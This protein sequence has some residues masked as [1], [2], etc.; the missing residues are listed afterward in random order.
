MPR[1]LAALLCLTFTILTAPL[2]RAGSLAPLH[3]EALPGSFWAP[4]AFIQDPAQDHIQY[5][6]SQGGLIYILENGVTRPQFF[7]DIRPQVRFFDEMGC[8]GLAF[9][10]DYADSG[11]FYVLF[12]AANPEG[13]IV[14]ARFKR[15]STN[16]FIADPASQFNLVF[17]GEP[18]IQRPPGVHNAGTIGFGPDGCLYVALGEAGDESLAQNPTSLHG[19]I[20]RID[21]AVPDTHATGH[22]IPPTNPFLPQNNPPVQNAR[23]E[24]WHVGLRNAW[25]WAFDDQGRGH[26]NAM[27]LGDVGGANY[28][29]IDVAPNNIPALNFGWP[30]LEGP[31]PHNN[32]PAMYLPLTDPAHS[33]PQNGAF[34]SV[35]AG[36]VN[37]NG[38][39]CSHFGRYFFADFGQGRIFSM[40]FDGVTLSDLVEHSTELLGGARP[41][42]PSFGRDA[43]GYLY[44]LTYDPGRVYRIRSDDAPLLGD[45]SGDGAVDFLDLNLVLSDF[46]PTYTFSDLNAVLS[47]FGVLCGQ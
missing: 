19:K 5:V 42:L 14:I 35:T 43:A 21:V 7:L 20:L 1:R 40:R 33:W 26:T 38:R 46:G 13:V 15:S 47:N 10:P 31:A 11:R 45:I 24:L 28:E 29:E 16:P 4:V 36:Y 41:F 23:P 18:Y 9:A 27:I 30:I 8:L 17:D 44:F 6:L 32:I 25:K 37:R 39:Q 22:V 2:A 12:S 34:S 3:A